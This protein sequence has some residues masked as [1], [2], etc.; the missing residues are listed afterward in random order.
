MLLGS[1][2]TVRRAVVPIGT[3]VRDRNGRKGEGLKVLYKGSD[4]EVN[5]AA[6]LGAE[7]E[8]PT[9]GVDIPGIDEYRGSVHG[10]P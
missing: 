7:H 2:H 6:A 5:G 4:P 9:L 8:Q 3:E 1:R 10:H